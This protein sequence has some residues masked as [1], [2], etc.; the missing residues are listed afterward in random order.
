MSDQTTPSNLSHLALERRKIAQFD[1]L[2]A[3]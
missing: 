3:E 1:K 2:L